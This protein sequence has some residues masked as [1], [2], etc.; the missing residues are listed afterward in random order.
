MHQSRTSAEKGFLTIVKT[1]RTGIFFCF[2]CQ[3]RCH[4]GLN[5]VYELEQLERDTASPLM[6]CDDRVA[7]GNE[8]LRMYLERLMIRWIKQKELTKLDQISNS[9]I[10]RTH[11]PK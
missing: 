3:G 1:L 8:E 5:L 4:H 9:L 6:Q 10:V 11:A 2:R 7:S